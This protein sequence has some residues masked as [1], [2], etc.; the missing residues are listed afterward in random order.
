MQTN[1]IRQYAGISYLMSPRTSWKILRAFV[2][3]TGLAR[4]YNTS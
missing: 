2:F 3:R 4:V 1:K